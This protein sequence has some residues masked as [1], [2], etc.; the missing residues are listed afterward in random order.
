MG[1]LIHC[2]GMFLRDMTNKRN[3]RREWMNSEDFDPHIESDRIASRILIYAVILS[4]VG[5]LVTSAF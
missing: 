1:R 3:K 2:L 4:F 5:L